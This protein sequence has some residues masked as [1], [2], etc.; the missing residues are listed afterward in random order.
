[1]A[2]IRDLKWPAEQFAMEVMLT[3]CAHQWH[4]PPHLRQVLQAYQ[5]SWMS[6]LVVENSFR[7]ARRKETGATGKSGILS[8]WHHLMVSRDFLPEFGR[9]HLDAHPDEHMPDTLTDAVLEQSGASVL[10]S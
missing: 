9:E 8:S 7:V 6:T 4:V 5:R 10:S 1:M 3:L 2:F